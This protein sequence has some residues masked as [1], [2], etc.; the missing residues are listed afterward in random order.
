MPDGWPVAAPAKEGLDPGLI[1]SIGPALK[2]LTAVNADGAAVA[3]HPNSVVVVRHDTLAYEHYLRGYDTHTLHL[4]AS[5]SKSVVALLAGIASDQGLPLAPRGGL[6]GRTTVNPTT[7][8][9]SSLSPV[10]NEDAAVITL[11]GCV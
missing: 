4:I 10:H 6:A 8:H 1:C 11:C 5:I 9:S 2:G 3:L 7:L